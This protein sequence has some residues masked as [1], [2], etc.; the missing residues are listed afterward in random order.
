[1]VNFTPLMLYY[2][3]ANVAFLQGSRHD[4]GHQPSFDIAFHTRPR[5]PM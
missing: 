4:E 2:L 3:Q 5:N 1:M